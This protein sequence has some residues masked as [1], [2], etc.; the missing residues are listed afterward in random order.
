MSQAEL[1]RR[2]GNLIEGADAG[3]T[4]SMNPA[5]HGIDEAMATIE[6]TVE[7]VEANSKLI[8]EIREKQR[9]IESV[10]LRATDIDRISEDTIRKLRGQLRLDRSRFS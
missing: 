5:R 6:E 9:A 8:D 1:E 4:Y 3:L 10:A 2:F 7:K